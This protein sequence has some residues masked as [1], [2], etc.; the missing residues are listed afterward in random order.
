MLFAGTITDH[1]QKFCAVERFG[2][3]VLGNKYAQDML[4]ELES[5]EVYTVD[6]DTFAAECYMRGAGARS[7]WK[8][9]RRANMLIYVVIVYSGES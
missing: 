2:G 4:I 6:K 3:A 1:N 9:C 8:G 5:P 7:T